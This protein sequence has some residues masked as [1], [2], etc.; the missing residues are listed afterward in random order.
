[1]LYRSN[2]AVVKQVAANLHNF[3][4]KGKT[5]YASDLHFNQVAESFPEHVTSPTPTAAP[6]KPSRRK[7]SMPDWR[8]PGREISFSSTR[9]ARTRRRFEAKASPCTC[10]ARLET[11]SGQRKTAPLLVKF[12]HKDGTVIFTSFHNEKQNNQTALK[13]LRYLVFAAM[14]ADVESQVT[15]T[16][17][18]GGFSPAK[19]RHLQHL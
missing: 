10:A 19:R 12:P 1:M 11:V 6:C 3:V 9:K 7:W 16:M 17:V 5:L 13:L 15:R 8:S 2:E 14:T 18:Q 4:G